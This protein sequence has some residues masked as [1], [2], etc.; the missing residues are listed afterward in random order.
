MDAH[1]DFQIRQQHQQSTFHG[2]AQQ[3]RS[4]GMGAFAMRMGR[5]AMP[6]VKTYVLPVAKE[7]GKKLVSSFVPELSNI[8][9]DKK[10]PRKAV[11][12]VLKQSANKTVAKATENRG[13]AAGAGAVVTAAGGGSGGGAKRP[14]RAGD[15]APPLRKSVRNGKK[16]STVIPPVAKNVILRKSP[17]K[18]SR[19]DILIFYPKSTLVNKK[20]PRE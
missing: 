11:G 4:A 7:F 2:P 14:V 10:R 3:F 12:D 15:R 1:Y 5:E 6:L 8:I 19:S 9:S 16:T 20:R 13:V 17:A 18:R